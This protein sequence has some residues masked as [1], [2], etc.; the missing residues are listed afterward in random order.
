MAGAC[1]AR[2]NQISPRVEDRF[3]ATLAATCNVN[4]ACAEAGVS[5]GAIY[6]HRKRWSAF[7]RRWDA[8]VKLGSLRLQ[9]ALVE[10]AANPFSA[11]ELPE[12]AEI[13]IEPVPMR[14]R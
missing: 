9:F 1:R 12:P 6:T 3:L 4:A 5:K 13:E 2:L 7:A 10:Y 8:A 11:T 14:R